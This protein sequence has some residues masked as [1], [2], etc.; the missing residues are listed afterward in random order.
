MNSMIRVY[1]TLAFLAFY[2]SSHALTPDCPPPH[3]ESVQTG[4]QYQGPDDIPNLPRW[5]DP[6]T[7]QNGQVPTSG[8]TVVILEESAVLLDSDVDMTSITV[9]G[10]LVVD[11]EINGILIQTEYI[12]IQGSGSLFEWGTQEIPFEGKGTINLKGEIP[13]V[14]PGTMGTIPNSKSIMAMMGG[15]LRIHG[16][17]KTSWTQLAKHASSGETMITIDGNP[18]EWMEGDEIAIA[19]SDFY[20]YTNTNFGL[21][22]DHLDQTEHRVITGINPVGNN[23]EVYFDDPLN[24]DHFGEIQDFNNGTRSWELD[25]RAEVGMLSRCIKIQGDESSEA[26]KFGGHVMIMVGSY[27]YVAGVEFYRMGQEAFK[28]RYPFHW[29]IC[30]DVNGQYINNSSL[31]HLYNRAITVHGSQNAL[32]DDN[33]VFETQGHAMF[34]EDAVETGVTFNHNLVMNVRRPAA[35][36]TAFIPADRGDDRNRVRGPSA[37]WITNPTNNF[38]NNHAAAI[39]GTA[40][41]LGL[42]DGPTGPS[43]GFSQYNSVKPNRAPFGTYTNNTAHGAMVGF[44]LDHKDAN[45]A[46]GV[47]NS[48]Y[49]TDSGWQTVTGLTAYNCFRGWWTRTHSLGIIFDET[50][51]ADC[52]GIGQSV[53]SFLG[54]TTNSLFVGHSAHSPNG[55]QFK[56]YAISLYDG[57]VSAENCHFENF[58]QTDQAVYQ[59]FGGRENKS[60]N[61]FT[62]CTNTN[63]ELFNPTIIPQLTTRLMSVTHDVDGQFTDPWGAICMY[64]PLLVDDKNFQM[65]GN[66][67]CYRTN[68]H[69][70][71]LRIYDNYN[72]YSPP[73]STNPDAGLQ[74]IEWDDGH[75]TH[76]DERLQMKSQTP[77][78]MGLGRTYKIRMLEGVP[79][80]LDLHLLYA[81]NNDELKLQILDSPNTLSVSTSSFAN[82]TSATDVWSSVTNAWHWDGDVLHIKMIATGGGS[83]LY[84]KLEAGSQVR[85]TGGNK[86][87]G[88]EPKH[89][90]HLDPDILKTQRLKLNGSIM[91][92]KGWLIKRAFQGKWCIIFTTIQIQMM[93]LAIVLNY[94]MLV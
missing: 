38:T 55:T 36:L 21:D 32:V 66:S 86:A 14:I 24:Y 18:L 77:V 23:T 8:S 43:A 33:V 12:L 67:R 34:L 58:D 57:W 44:H 92:D 22:D 76:T 7:W 15:T 25:E 89:H 94:S 35:G 91:A 30:H 93:R 53:T 40:F 42:P 70:A 69:F 11:P 83:G 75:C 19:S 84:D 4:I 47:S 56:T 54:K 1:Y 41:W 5:S 9:E 90:D 61:I 62:G 37:Y 48:T 13:Y 50:V 74:Y 20:E 71:A 63:A 28:A 52:P 45:N 3:F 2:L 10:Q 80:I 39:Q 29:H 88:I 51:M 16:R 64:H 49:F 85:V 82:K 17:T 27:G 26:S 72:L 68:A 81:M 6:A 59:Y 78:A 87:L 79:N 65:Q 46:A 73:P 60:N 31:H